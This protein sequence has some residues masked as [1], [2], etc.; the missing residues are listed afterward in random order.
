MYDFHLKQETIFC[1]LFC[2][3]SAVSFRVSNCFGVFLLRVSFFDEKKFFSFV[4]CELD[5]W[6][7]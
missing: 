5:C 7:F 1:F 6:I 2:R 3:I 4:I